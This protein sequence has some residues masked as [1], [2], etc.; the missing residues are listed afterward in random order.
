M[1]LLSLAL[2]LTPLPPADSVNAVWVSASGDALREVGGYRVVEYRDAGE[3]GGDWHL[4]GDGATSGNGPSQLWLLR[5]PAAAA[6]ALSLPSEAVAFMTAGDHNDGFATFLVDGVVVGTYD[7][8]RR[9]EKTLLVRGLARR[10]HVLEVRME[11][12]KRRRSRDNHVA[13]YGGAAL[14]RDDPLSLRLKR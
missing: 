3:D 5:A 1:L 9:G 2:L 10:A 6:V 11:G 12:R 14:E 8:Y 4:M 7:M 13:V